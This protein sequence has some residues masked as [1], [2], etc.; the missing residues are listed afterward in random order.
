MNGVW[1]SVPC[2]HPA[3]HDHFP[4]N[5]ILPAVVIFEQVVV[6]ASKAG[7]AVSVL[8]SARLLREIRPGEPFLVRF[9]QREGGVQFLV[10]SPDGSVLARGRLAAS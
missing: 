3:L 4:G 6:A 8:S 10:E 7:L 5:P 2:D 9:V 1:C